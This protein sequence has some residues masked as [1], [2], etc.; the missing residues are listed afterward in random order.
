M[1]HIARAVDLHGVTATSASDRPTS[2]GL[3][4]LRESLVG[5]PAKRLRSWGVP[6][7][8]ASEPIVLGPRDSVHVPIDA[9]ATYLVLAT[10][11]A[12]AIPGADPVGPDG[13]DARLQAEFDA[14]GELVAELEL[15]FHDGS[16][17]TVPVRRRFETGP[18]A[19]GWGRQPYLARAHREDGP[20][21]PG[22]PY[23]VAGWGYHQGAVSQGTYHA[24]T[25]WLFAVENPHP[26]LEIRSIRMSGGTSA[27]ALLGITLWFGEERPL[28]ARTEIHLALDGPVDPAAV[29]VVDGTLIR[30]SLVE[31]PER[32]AWLADSGL[33]G[34][35]SA[36]APAERL[37]VELAGNDGT[38]LRVG[39]HSIA[40]RRL[41]AGQRHFI[42]G[43]PATRLSLPTIPVTIRITEAGRSV[44]GRIHL[45]AADGRELAP[46][47][48]GRLVSDR[49]FEDRGSDVL[50]GGWR[51]A[52]VADDFQV[53][54]PPGDLFAEVA[55]GPEYEGLR[56]VHSVTADGEAAVVEIEPKRIANLRDEGWLASDTHVHFVAPNA[57]HRQARA[58]GLQLVHLMGAQWGELFT[59]I[60]DLGEGPAAASEDAV[61]WAGTENRHHALGHLLAVGTPTVRPL[62]SGGPG[63]SRIADSNRVTI[64]D[65]AHQTRATG[66][67]AILAHFP[68]PYLEVVADLLLGRVDAIELWFWPKVDGH[69]TREW[70]RFLN[71]GLRIP[72]IAGTDKM[73]A[74][75]VLGSVRTYTHTGSRAIDFGA[76]AEA[77]RAGR[78]MVTTGPLLE[79]AI[80]DLLPGSTLARQASHV[81][82]WRVRSAAPVEI[83]EIVANGS[84]VYRERL[85]GLG[86]WEGSVDL[87]L[88]RR[89]WVAGR[90]FG[91]DILTD[92]RTPLPFQIGAHTSPIYLPDP[93]IPDPADVTYFQTLLEGAEGWG[94]LAAWEA[95]E[96]RARFEALIAEARLIL[97]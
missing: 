81:C 84:I 95:D 49:F 3:I 93:A 54:A 76:W 91:P 83:F 66:G 20:V 40:L 25:A 14:V 17:S 26:G 22:G 44:A 45:R 35:G 58:E 32:E 1:S 60:E 96:I 73:Y 21:D 19:V 94:R 74:S 55:R 80:D 70:Y 43:V 67:V 42:G 50:V 88:P 46:T 6:L 10:C 30:S 37:I 61:V 34:L 57:L 18:P 7:K 53:L 2:G 78:T 87:P 39:R 11:C 47:D 69:R 9:L 77:V 86:P 48:R 24:P 75:T 27:S 15:T 82:R 59:N 62:S 38:K 23:P 16:H 12:P 29:S 92:A 68:D 90:C 85:K 51:Y 65:W 64:A 41:T 56:S 5:L 13:D 31:P 4:G 71:L 97:R 8:F 33:H 89:G 52:Y 28:S 72:I 63:E 79:F 36:D